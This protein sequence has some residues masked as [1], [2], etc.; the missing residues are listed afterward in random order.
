MAARSHYAR[1]SSA[2]IQR[3]SACGWLGLVLD[4]KV[5]LHRALRRAGSAALAL[6][7]RSFDVGDAAE[8]AAFRDARRQTPGLRWL[9]HNGL[10]GDGKGTS[11]LQ[12]GREPPARRRH[13]I[14]SQLIED[15][16]LV[17]GV[18]SEMRV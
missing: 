16:L 5:R 11:L 7:P 15:P 6:A 8:M 12:P 3:C 2:W 18:K 10:A 17:E 4:N 1:G 13:A 9:V 14:V